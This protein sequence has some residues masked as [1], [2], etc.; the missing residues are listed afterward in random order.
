VRVLHV[1]ESNG[2][3]DHV[4]KVRQFVHKIVK[5]IQVR[6]EYLT[7]RQAGVNEKYKQCD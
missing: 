3:N 7:I 1:I 5:S 2:Q 4:L 6:A